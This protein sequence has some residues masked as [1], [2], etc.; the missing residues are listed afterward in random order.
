MITIGRRG[1]IAGAAGAMAWP[2]AV[3]A[4]QRAMPVVGFL[5][6]TESVGAAVTPFRQGLSETGYIEGRNVEI[7]H[8]YTNLDYAQLPALAANLVGSRV[9]VIVAITGGSATA[10]AAKKATT[11]IPI[12]FVIGAD[13]VGSGLVVS[14]NRPGANVTGAT[15]LTTELLAKQV[16][17]L[18]EAVPAAT[19]IGVL[20]NPTAAQ[21]EGQKREAENAARILGIK[22]LILNASAPDEFESAFKRLDGQGNG[23][24]VVAGDVLFGT[25]LSALA[26]LSARYKVPTIHYSRNFVEADGLMSYGASMS[27]AWRIAGTYVGRILKGEK[28]GDLPVQQSTR[29]EMALN[30]KTAKALG[31]NVPTSILLR[32]DQVIE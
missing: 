1:F 15:F 17:L 4:Q 24:L 32:A 5:D 25:R 23:A 6:A 22:L 13:P 27:D 26:A 30:L 28:P 20:V 7:L 3:R 11:T 16:E 8:R 9:D 31:L 18:H 2:L 12:V 10:L 29:I 21:T 19:T 14:L